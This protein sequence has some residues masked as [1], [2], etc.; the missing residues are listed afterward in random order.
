MLKNRPL[1]A[2]FRPFACLFNAGCR[3]DFGNKI[4]RHGE[5]NTHAD[6]KL[7]GQFHLEPVSKVDRRHHD[8]QR[9]QWIALSLLGKMRYQ[10]FQ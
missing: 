1:Q 10:L 4:L 7:A 3:E 2:P 5:F 6:T 9:S 8:L